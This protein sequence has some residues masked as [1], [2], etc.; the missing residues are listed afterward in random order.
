MSDEHT[1]QGGTGR[2]AIFRPGGLLRCCIQA[3]L[4]ADRR[5]AEGDRLACP[6]CG[7]EAVWR[8]GAWE[9]SAAE[10]ARASRAVRGTA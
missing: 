8:D 9:W 2:A 3:I 1:F 4:A 10:A 5:G 7:A 6:E